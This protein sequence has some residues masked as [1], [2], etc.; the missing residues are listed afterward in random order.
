MNK[1]DRFKRD[2]DSVAKESLIVEQIGGSIY[3]FGSELAC[4][5]L[6]FYYNNAS[7]NKNSTMKFSP[8]RGSYFFRLET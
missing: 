8:A 4:L 7:H 1:L 2:W 3:A 6:F 5:R